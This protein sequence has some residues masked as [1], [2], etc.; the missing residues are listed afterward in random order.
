[1]K[2]YILFAKYM[3]SSAFET[4]LSIILYKQ[5]KHG[6]KLLPKVQVQHFSCL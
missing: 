3:C 6:Q 4:A 5:G 1:M 2:K